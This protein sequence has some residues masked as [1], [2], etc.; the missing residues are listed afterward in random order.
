[1][2]SFRYEELGNGIR[3]YIPYKTHDCIHIQS[4]P[5]M[6]WYIG[7]IALRGKKISDGFRNVTVETKKTF[8][9]IFQREW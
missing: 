4:Q 3:V 8:P 7:K 5:C 6:E 2:E 1:M 9:Y